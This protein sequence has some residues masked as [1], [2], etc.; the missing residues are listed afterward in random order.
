M[1]EKLSVG[2]L[3]AV[4]K[5]TSYAIAVAITCGI[6]LV[7]GHLELISLE[8]AGVDITTPLV[9]FLILAF[10]VGI[11]IPA[12]RVTSWAGVT[13]KN[14]WAEK[15]SRREDTKTALLELERVRKELENIN[16]EERQILSYLINKNSR[17]FHAPAGEEK[18]VS[19][20][21]K[22][23]VR[24]KNIGVGANIMKFPH[25]IPEHI[26]EELQQRRIDFQPANQDGRRMIWPIV[27]E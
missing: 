27:D 26:W 6:T 23:I 20:I 19:L 2:V 8:V 9:I 5:G 24:P 13:I 22:R 17:W 18:L 10:C 1:N 14:W 11:C 21:G 25:Y 4:F 16:D 12:G 15:A 7:L 3:Q